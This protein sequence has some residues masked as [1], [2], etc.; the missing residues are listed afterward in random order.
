MRTPENHGSQHGSPRFEP[1]AYAL[2]WQIFFAGLALQVATWLVKL[3]GNTAFGSH[4]RT[5]QIPINDVP[6]DS[7][8]DPTNP[9]IRPKAGG[10]TA[11]VE[12]T[13]IFSVR[14]AEK[15][16]WAAPPQY[17]ISNRIACMRPF[18]ACFYWQWFG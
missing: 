9:H 17:D 2:V 8:Q 12:R 5:W 1:A 10:C 6:P 16:N 15:S 11:P 7:L 4:A 18:Q 14:H 3:C 13:L